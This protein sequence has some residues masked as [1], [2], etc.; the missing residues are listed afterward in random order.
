MNAVVNIAVIG[1]G[2]IGRMHA[3]HLAHR[4][5]GAALVAVADVVEEAARAC[6]AACGGVR[7]VRDYHALLD[8]PAVD[9]V[10]ICSATPTH[11]P[12]IVAAAAAGKHVFCKK[13]IALDL[14]EIDRALAAVDRAGVQLQVGFNRRFDANFGR[15]RQAIIGGEIGVPHLLQITSR[16]P[17]PPPLAYIRESGGLFL[18][19]TIHDFDMARFLIGD[20]VEE[21][22]AVGGVRVDPAIGAAGDLDTAAVMLR[23]VGGTIGTINNSRRA[24]YGYDQRAEV[25]GSGGMISIGNDYPNTARISTETSVHRDL[26]HTFFLDRYTESFIAE[27][28]AFADAVRANRPPPVTGNDGRI[29][30][31]LGMAAQQSHAEHRPI[32]VR[33]G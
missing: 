25:F 24:V 5:P 21:V 16:D 31:V 23:F 13:P 30:V 2:R 20:E 14:P 19:M 4:V 10:A 29:A 26:P 9:A 27:L 15:V 7:A 3:A 1:A 11:A 6:A 28:R 33:S 22:Y 18:D 17:A 8:D 32:R 12:I